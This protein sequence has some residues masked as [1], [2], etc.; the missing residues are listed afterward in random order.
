MYIYL[1]IMYLFTEVEWSS[2]GGEWGGVSTLLNLI[3]YKEGGGIEALLMLIFKQLYTIWLI[4]K[5][6]MMINMG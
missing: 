4:V 1:F 5:V 2:G 6:K 3:H